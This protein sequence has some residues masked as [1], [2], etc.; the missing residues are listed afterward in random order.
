MLWSLSDRENLHYS[1]PEPKANFPWI[2]G[3]AGIAVTVIPKD[4]NKEPAAI[5]SDFEFPSFAE[6]TWIKELRLYPMWVFADD[7]YGK[8]PSTAKQEKGEQF[9]LEESF[10]Q[11]KAILA[12]K[13]LE[14]GKIGVEKSFIQVP[15]WELLKK[16]LPDAELINSDATWIDSRIIKM[17]MGN[18]IFRES[19]P[20][21]RKSP[22]KSG[23]HNS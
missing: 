15:S 5:T 10:R 19:L 14:R 6:N 12:E 11:L 9:G 13:G 18:R 8:G 7:T 17:P 20:G 21:Y 2:W 4:A 3:A 1:S 22:G 16:Y 23:Q